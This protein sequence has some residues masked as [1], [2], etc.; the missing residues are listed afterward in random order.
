MTGGETKW[1]IIPADGE[2]TRG[3]RA[4]LE[5]QV[6]EE[7]FSFFRNEFCLVFLWRF[8]PLI[9]FVTYLNRRAGVRHGYPTN[10]VNAGCLYSF[11]LAEI[12]TS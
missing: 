4:K 7:T 9:R 11:R 1:V 6:V 8:K 10:E 5:E 2:G 3:R 12:T